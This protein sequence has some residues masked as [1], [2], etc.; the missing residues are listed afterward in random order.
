MTDQNQNVNVPLLRK[1]VEWAEAEAAKPWEECRWHQA[2]W[3][4]NPWD[5]FRWHNDTLQSKA[6]GCGTCYCVAGYVGELEGFDHRG[7]VSEFAQDTL[8]LSDYDANRLFH[9]S[10]TIE[11]VRRVAEEIA[12][13]RL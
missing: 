5:V 7:S 2:S 8:G 13:E 1:A 10:N 6:A 3:S 11:D 9:A 4:A 12:G